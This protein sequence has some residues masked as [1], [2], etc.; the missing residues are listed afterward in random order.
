MSAFH[1][2]LRFLRLA[3]SGLGVV[4][5]SKDMGF[6]FK[7]VLNFEEVA[8]Q[9]L[10]EVAGLR[11]EQLNELVSWTGRP[12]GDIRMHFRGE[13]VPSRALRSPVVRGC[14]D[15]LRADI[16]AQSV[17]PLT[18][19]TYRGD[20]QLK[21]AKVCIM[22]N[23]PLVPLWE[24]DTP[25][26]RW[27]FQARFL[28]LQA[29][30]GAAQAE[31]TAFNVTAHDLW[32][33]RRLRT[34]KDGTWFKGHTVFAAARLCKHIGRQIVDHGLVCMGLPVEEDRPEQRG[35]RSLVVPE[36]MVAVIDQ[37]RTNVEPPTAAAFARS[38]GLRKKGAFLAFIQDGHTPATLIENP[39]TGKAAYHMT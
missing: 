34:G 9:T 18:A 26:R 21:D 32:L 25:L 22:H 19:I 37:R 33:D 2:V 10:A 8:L 27:D 35:Y 23:R 36:S 13:L 20:W 15:C 14:P 38:I 39:K 28:D 30:L 24:E 12:A 16:A 7:R 5:F 31:E 6:S 17:A 4:E 29:T 11:A 1:V 3:A